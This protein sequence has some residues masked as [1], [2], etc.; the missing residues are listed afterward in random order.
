MSATTT[1]LL[2]GRRVL[3]TALWQYTC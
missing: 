3:Q 1:Q 2:S